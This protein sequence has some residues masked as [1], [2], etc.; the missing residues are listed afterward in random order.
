MGDVAKKTTG[1]TGEKRKLERVDNESSS[2][3]WS[4]SQLRAAGVIMTKLTARYI[5]RV[6]NST[7]LV[8]AMATRDRLLQSIAEGDKPSTSAILRALGRLSIDRE[9]LKITGLGHLL[10][11]R[12]L[13]RQSSEYDGLC[14]QQLRQKWR[15]QT[16]HRG[17]VDL[18]TI[19][20][21]LFAV[22]FRASTFRDRVEAFKSWLMS[23]DDTP[24]PEHF[25]TRLAMSLV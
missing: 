12:S 3:T 20:S 5:P 14:A 2:P 16:P 13:W 11:D 17:T 7:E 21:P 8:K 15:W 6:S 4:A 24:I 25:R 18:S 1:C 9:I 22:G 19:P 23:I 10:N